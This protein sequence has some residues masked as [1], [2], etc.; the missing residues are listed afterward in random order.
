MRAYGTGYVIVQRVS[1]GR[2]R[3]PSSTTSR[4]NCRLQS[5][6]GLLLQLLL[7]RLLRNFR[8]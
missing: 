2:V 4:C 8:F 5:L 3:L 6:Q 1:A 7:V